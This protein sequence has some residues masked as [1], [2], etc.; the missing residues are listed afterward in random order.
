MKSSP[1]FLSIMIM[2][3]LAAKHHMVTEA[4]FLGNKRSIF[5]QYLCIIKLEER[6]RKQF[7]FF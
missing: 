4:A 5:A 7:C 1:D 2:A 6:C 3:K